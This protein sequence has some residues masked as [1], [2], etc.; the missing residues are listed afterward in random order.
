[1]FLAFGGDNVSES[2]LDGIRSEVESLNAARENLP[3][4]FEPG[5]QIIRARFTVPV[6][7]LE[8]RRTIAWAFC[9]WRAARSAQ[10][11][12]AFVGGDVRSDSVWFGS[13]A[14]KPVV[15]IEFERYSSSSDGPKL[16]GKVDSLL[17]AH[18]RWDQQA[19]LLVLAYWTKRPLNLPDHT[20]LR[21]RIRNGFET[22]ARE[23]VHGASNCQIAFFQTIVTEA[24]DERWKLSRL[25][26]EESDGT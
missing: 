21:R 3:F 8:P 26:S 15:L 20:Q 2:I 13:D 18:H 24:H 6:F 7:V 14:Q 9:R 10:G 19:T 16:L 23:R 4:W 1:M 5:L 17:L 25:L 11:P 12:L 22:T